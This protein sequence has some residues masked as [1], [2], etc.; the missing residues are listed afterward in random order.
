MTI[1]PHIIAELAKLTGELRTTF[2]IKEFFL[3]GS[4]ARGED[5]PDSDV[6]VLVEFSSPIGLFRFLQLEE[7]LSERLN[8]PVELVSRNALKGEIGRSILEESLPI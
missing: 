6:D 1:K 2:P 8:R 7:T 5:T 4:V 3:F